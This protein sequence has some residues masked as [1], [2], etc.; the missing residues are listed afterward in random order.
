M[1][2]W[3]IKILR[4]VEVDITLYD[5]YTEAIT[6]A[7]AVYEAMVNKP[8]AFKVVLINHSGDILKEVYTGYDAAESK[9]Y[10]CFRDILE[11]STMNMAQFSR[12]YGIPYRTVQNW[13]AGEEPQ[14]YM[15]S[16]LAVAVFSNKEV[17]G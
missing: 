11:A 4:G 6:E 3:A 2:Q 9:E 8:D 16:L 10:L 1:I 17:S 13:V 14:I 15:L 5:S 12:A 7:K